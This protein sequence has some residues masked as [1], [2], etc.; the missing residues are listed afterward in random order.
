[1]R[2][3]IPLLIAASVAGCT[4]QPPASLVDVRGQARLAEMLRGKVAGEPQK[5]IPQRLSSYFDIIDPTTIAVRDGSRIYVNHVQGACS[6]LHMG[7]HALVVKTFGFGGP[8][9]GDTARVTDLSSGNVMGSCLLGDFVPYN[10]I[11]G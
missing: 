3:L 10:P 8:C 2:I 7:N 5:C 6:G 9:R 11:R 4:A 1:M